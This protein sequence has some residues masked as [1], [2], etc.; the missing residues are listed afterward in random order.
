MNGIAL[1]LKAR[2]AL[3][4]DLRGLLPTPLLALDDAALAAW[5]LLHGNDWLALAELFHIQRFDCDQPTLRLAGELQRADHIGRGLASG[6]IVV[7][8][9][10]G[11]HAG[12]SM[13][14]GELLVQGDAGLLAGCQMAGGRLEVQGSVGDHAASGL[15]GSMDGMRGGLFIVH[16]HAGR[17]LA[18]R[19]RR[20][21]LIVLGDVADFAASRLVAGTLVL[22]GRVGAH[23]GWGQRRG[24]L[25]LLDT[26]LQP[27]PTWVPAGADAPVAWQLLARDISRIAADLGPSAAA[28]CDLPR[29]AVRRHLGDL[30]VDGRGELIQPL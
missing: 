13:S 7:Q 5:P 3:R 21:T 29:R 27:G 20:G 8:A 16:G 17:R 23:P 1:T 9:G 28:L 18:D 14:G 19:M 30:A 26:T 6:R 10:V 22:A 25:V 15:P 2:P 4:L 12:T 11:D 24:S